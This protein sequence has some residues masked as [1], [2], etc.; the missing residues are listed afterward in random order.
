MVSTVC[1]LPRVRSKHRPP[2]PS[3]KTTPT[4]FFPFKSSRRQNRRRSQWA[5]PFYMAGPSPT[6]FGAKQRTFKIAANHTQATRT[7]D[8]NEYKG[9]NNHSCKQRQIQYT[10]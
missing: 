8:T 4:N 10:Y 5:L 1:P 7:I 6:K 9:S 2:V 3:R